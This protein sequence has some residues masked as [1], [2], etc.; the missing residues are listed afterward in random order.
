MMTK[1]MSPKRRPPSKH[2]RDDLEYAPPTKSSRQPPEPAEPAPT[3]K[4][5]K[6]K[7]AEKVLA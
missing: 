6:E 1:E 2:H 7:P 3:S 4:K 5:S